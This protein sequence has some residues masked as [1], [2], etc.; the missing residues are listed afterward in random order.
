MA[1]IEIEEF[2]ERETELVFIART[3]REP[4][5]SRRC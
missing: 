4:G 5:G 1:R 3:V 2:D